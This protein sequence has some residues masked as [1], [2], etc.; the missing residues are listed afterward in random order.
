MVSTSRNPFHISDNGTCESLVRMTCDQLPTKNVYRIPSIP[1]IEYIIIKI[2]KRKEAHYWAPLFFV[3]KSFH[4]DVTHLRSS[5]PGS[6]G[7]DSPVITRYR[8]LNIAIVT[9]SRSETVYRI[10]PSTLSIIIFKGENPANISWSSGIVS[11]IV[12]ITSPSKSAFESAD[13]SF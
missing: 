5:A 1:N 3:R 13:I 10:L 6:V 9:D 11:I 4:G 7:S 2:K 8:S 12:L